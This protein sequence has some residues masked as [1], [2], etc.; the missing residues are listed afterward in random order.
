[1]ALVN[2][3]HPKFLNEKKTEEPCNK[4]NGGIATFGQMYFDR[5]PNQIQKELSK[6]Q[7]RNTDEK[8]KFTTKE[9]IDIYV[10]S[11]SILQLDVDCIVNE[12]N[13]R[14]GHR[15][16]VAAVIAS[17]AGYELE[18]EGKEYIERYGPIPVGECCH[19]TAGRLPYK[20]VIHTV[21]P[22]WSNSMTLKEQKQCKKEL[23]SAIESCFYE[24]DILRMK[25]IGVP[26]VSAGIQ[27][28]TWSSK[29]TTLKEIHFID[30]N[31]EMCKQ[32]ADVF[33]KCGDFKEAG[34]SVGSKPSNISTSSR[35]SFSHSSYSR[36]S[37]NSSFDRN[38]DEA[39]SS[40]VEMLFRPCSWITIHL[41]QSSITDIKKVS[42]VV[43]PENLG[44]K[45]QGRIS[46][47]IL[48]K[49]DED[50][51]DKVEVMKDRPTSITSVFSIDCSK[52]M[53]W[54][55][56]LYSIAPR[57]D[58]KY[59]QNIQQ[60]ETDLKDTVVNILS[61]AAI[62]RL[63][64]LAIPLLGTGII[65]FIICKEEHPNPGKFYS[66]IERTGFLPDNEKAFTSSFDRRLVFTIGRSRTTGQEGVITWNDIHHKTRTH[67]GQQSFGYPDDT[68]LDRV[69]DELAAKGH[70]IP[71]IMRKM[72]SSPS[73][74]ESFAPCLDD[75][76]LAQTKLLQ[77][78]FKSLI[79]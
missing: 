37:S 41:L 39:Y 75:E 23:Q 73:I 26:S 8:K 11:E 36:S 21:G 38:D 7:N 24:A 20:Y 27:Q 62:K 55:C 77:K 19:T 46:K 16:G 12:A 30:M 59:K 1:M 40:S 28:R 60:F 63:E 69:L 70:K 34:L 22:R 67:G 32:I 13:E 33:S 2:K 71:Q 43:S 35:H 10:Y 4:E 79:G 56:V 15:A 64:S 44:F 57:L 49:A 47:A 72:D 29:P 74:N 45:H 66:G 48:D 18:Q 14:L 54:K 65:Y 52:E 6:Q 78:Y 31:I 61:E 5:K 42:A 9:K 76:N 50:F 53:P 17:A 51:R 58:S 25:S 3:D 68:Y